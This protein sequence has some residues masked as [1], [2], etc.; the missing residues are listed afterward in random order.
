MAI[1]QCYDWHQ[2]ARKSI[3]EV[4]NA[5]AA[6]NYRYD[7]FISY[8]HQDSAFSQVII[9]NMKDIDKELSIFIDVQSL[10]VRLFSSISY[11]LYS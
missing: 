9:D 7:V 2:Q 8:C 1:V 11:R 4:D 10:K 6:I 3:D 5:Q